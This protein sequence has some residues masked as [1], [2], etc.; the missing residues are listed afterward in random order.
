MLKAEAS[1]SEISYEIPTIFTTATNPDITEAG[2]FVFM[3]A[4]T[5]D[6]QGKMMAELATEK[7]GASTAAV[8]V[9]DGDTHSE[10][11][12]KV[13]IEN[14]TALGG[15]IVASESYQRDDLY[16]GEQLNTIAQSNPDVILMPGYAPEVPLVAG[17]AK[18]IGIEAPLLG[19]TG[20]DSPE[21]LKTIGGEALEGSLFLAHFSADVPI[22]Q[23][24]EEARRFISEYKARYHG[25]LP[26]SSDALS[27]DAARILAQ[28]IRRVSNDSSAEISTAEIIDE[29][30]TTREYRG[31]TDIV[32]YNPNRQPKKSAVV[33]IIK[34]GKV[35]FHLLTKPQQ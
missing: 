35:K 27:Y 32:S 14:F 29:I 22:W 4:F 11:L 25:E 24:S 20:W 2:D 19:G 31:A 6:F 17:Q 5:D 30:A 33:N 8:L 28:A 21:L 16:F 1:D 26:N 7:L 10:G 12:S 13:F 34:D 18:A 15:T 3:V 23:L 9:Q